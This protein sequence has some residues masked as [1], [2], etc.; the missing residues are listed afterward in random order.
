MTAV[1][2]MREAKELADL[3]VA[4]PANVEVGDLY[5]LVD[6]KTAHYRHDPKSAYPVDHF[7]Y[8]RSLPDGRTLTVHFGTVRTTGGLPRMPN[9]NLTITVRPSDRNNRGFDAEN[10]G[11]GPLTTFRRYISPDFYLHWSDSEHEA[12]NG[13]FVDRVAKRTT[14]VAIDPVA[15]QESVHNAYLN[16]IKDVTAVIKGEQQNITVT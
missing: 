7:T 9:D 13:V 16:L 12:P 2:I 1:T 6:G 10:T 5:A 3:L 8:Y 15:L 14:T 4:G 11:L